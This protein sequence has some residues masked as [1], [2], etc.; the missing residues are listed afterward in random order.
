MQIYTAAEAKIKKAEIQGRIAKGD[1]FIHPTDTI[2]GIGCNALISNAVKKIREIKER[3]DTPFSIMVPS[4]EWIR[5]N[6]VITKQA[7]KYLKELPGQ[8][9]LILKTIN[10]P[11]APEVAP[12]SDTLGV[13]IPKHWFHSI[14]EELEI[15]VITTSVNK[16]GKAFMTSI[17]SLD[18]EIAKDIDFAIDEGKKEGRPS[19]IINLTGEKPAIKER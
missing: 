9:T 2:Y 17:D 12:G 19:K 6:C 10:Q 18:T 11:V 14:I 15:P 5:E 1:I 4:I 8:V 7:E 16:M 13:R 3:P